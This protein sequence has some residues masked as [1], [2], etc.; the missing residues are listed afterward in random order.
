MCH[1]LTNESIFIVKSAASGGC[2]PEWRKRLCRGKQREE[3]LQQV[4]T[5]VLLKMVAMVI[6]MVMRVMVTMMM[7]AMMLMMPMIV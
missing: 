4:S 5:R 6:I 7:M 3:S 1:Q 2:R